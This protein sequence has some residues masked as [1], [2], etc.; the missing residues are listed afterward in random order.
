[1]VLIGFRGAFTRSMEND[2]LVL[3]VAKG[4]CLPGG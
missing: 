4:K 1:M 3:G 2:C